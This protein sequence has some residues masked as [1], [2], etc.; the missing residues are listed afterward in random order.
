MNRVLQTY[1]LNILNIDIICNG[2]ACVTESV[3]LFSLVVPVNSDINQAYRIR[4]ESDK[5]LI[6]HVSL[7]LFN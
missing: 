4:R 2:R 3:G 5:M 6:S 7:Q 1:C